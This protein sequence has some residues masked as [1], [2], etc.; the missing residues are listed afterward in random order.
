MLKYVAKFP[1]HVLFRQSCLCGQPRLGITWT[2]EG[3]EALSGCDV[4]VLLPAQGRGHGRV[5]EAVG[6]R[7]PLPRAG[8]PLPS[9]LPSGVPAVGP[10]SAESCVP[11]TWSTTGRGCLRVTGAGQAPARAE[12]KPDLLALHGQTTRVVPFTRPAEA[13]ILKKKRKEKRIGIT[14]LPSAWA[15]CVFG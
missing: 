7:T 8:L 9:T 14:A 15:M 1:N 10:A 12:L 13:K 3:P 2:A 11:P 5:S 4:T 6:C